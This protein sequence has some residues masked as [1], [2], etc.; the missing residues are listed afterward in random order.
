MIENRGSRK[1]NTVHLTY[2]QVI[3]FT[4]NLDLARCKEQKDY[5]QY[6]QDLKN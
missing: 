2:S 4:H 1:A 6:N 5:T 3:G